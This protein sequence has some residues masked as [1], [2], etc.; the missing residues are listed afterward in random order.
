MSSKYYIPICIHRTYLETTL[1]RKAA[2]AEPKKFMPGTEPLAGS[3]IRLFQPG[4]GE[5]PNDILGIAEGIETAIS[6]TQL[7]KV[8]TWAVGNTALME[9]WLPPE[10]MKQVIIFADNDSG[11]GGQKSA[12]IL[13]NRLQKMHILVIVKIPEKADTDYNDVLIEQFTAKKRENRNG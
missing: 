7:F 13:A 9:K 5:Y 8:A 3:A 2:I 4:V 6:A 10:D 1:P 12:M 11:F